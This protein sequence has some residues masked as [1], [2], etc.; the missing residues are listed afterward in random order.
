MSTPSVTQQPQDGRAGKPSEA[1]SP[2]ST[3]EERGRVENGHGD[4]SPVPLSRA[5]L[6]VGQASGETSSAVAM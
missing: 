2:Q 1:P 5:T 6:P 4:P 3:T